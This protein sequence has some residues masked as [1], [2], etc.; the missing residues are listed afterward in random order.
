[1]KKDLSNKFKIPQDYF[2]QM[3]SEILAK[4]GI[5]TQSTK[6][7]PFYSKPIFQAAASLLIVLMTGL[8]I[9]QLN[10]V[11]IN[12]QDETFAKEVIY[13]VYFNDQPNHEFD[14]EEDVILAEFIYD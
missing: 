3:E 12:P 7:I 1:M 6:I 14:L 13:D 9:W 10:K 11:E 2:D 5:S 4:T 8:G